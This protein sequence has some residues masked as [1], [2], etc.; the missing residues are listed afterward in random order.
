MPHLVIQYSSNLQ[1]D[2]ELQTLCD[3]LYQVMIESGI[4]PLAGIRVRASS[5]DAYCIADLKPDNTFVDMVLRIG[6][7]RSDEE[8][9]AVGEHLMQV[10]SEYCESLLADARIMLSLEIVEISK[11]MSWKINPIHQRL[12]SGQ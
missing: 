12:Q 2:I 10:A 7:G 5:C 3:R 6:E 11:S 4:F 9:S 1:S 8:K